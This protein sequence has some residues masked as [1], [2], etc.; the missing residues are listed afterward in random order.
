MGFLQEATPGGDEKGYSQALVTVLSLKAGNAAHQAFEACT[1]FQT[2]SSSSIVAL[3]FGV[4]GF[5]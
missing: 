5:G 4:V 3:A 2:V 1:P